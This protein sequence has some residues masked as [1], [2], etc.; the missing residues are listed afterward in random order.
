M[1]LHRNQIYDTTRRGFDT[2]VTR[3]RATIIGVMTQPGEV[4]G[5]LCHN[6]RNPYYSKPTELS[7]G[8]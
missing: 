7:K 6:P 2:S 1:C 8:A 3:A 4:L 5:R